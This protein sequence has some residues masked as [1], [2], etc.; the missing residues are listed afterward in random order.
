[1]YLNNLLSA[2]INLEIMPNPDRE[3]TEQALASQEAEQIQLDHN[4][5][6]LFVTILCC[7]YQG[8]Q[9]DDHRQMKKV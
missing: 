3:R 6:E 8:T 4:Q 9:S 5:K 7:N 2:N 1:V